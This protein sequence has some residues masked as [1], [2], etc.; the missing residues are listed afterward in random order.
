M[1]FMIT[2]LLPNSN[3]VNCSESS[4]WSSFLL[5]LVILDSVSTGSQQT[6]FLNA[7]KDSPARYPFTETNCRSCCKR[8]SEIWF[9]LFSC[10]YWNCVFGTLA[11]YFSHSKGFLVTCWR[12]KREFSLNWFLLFIDCRVVLLTKICVFLA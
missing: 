2:L 4:L 8:I 11:L 7:L 10:C 5:T 9:C 6:G 1:H 3:F 12:Q